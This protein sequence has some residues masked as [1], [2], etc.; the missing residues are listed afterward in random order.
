MVLFKYAE[1]KDVIQT[2]Y[3]MKFPKHLIHGVSASDKSEASMI[4]KV[5]E[6]CGFEYT[7]KLQ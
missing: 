6:A 5:K 4:S 2:F 3:A 7:N 1:N